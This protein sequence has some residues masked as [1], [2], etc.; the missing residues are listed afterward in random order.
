MAGIRDLL[1][2]AFVMGVEG[3][4]GCHQQASVHSYFPQLPVAHVFHV[5]LTRWPVDSGQSQR[6]K[7]DMS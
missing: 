3:L 2:F 5:T 6:R 1:R 7:V 4:G